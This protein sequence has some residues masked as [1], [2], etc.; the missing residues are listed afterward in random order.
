MKHLR[1]GSIAAADQVV[2]G[3]QAGLGA[4][5]HGDDDLLVGRGRRVAGGEDAGQ[6]GLA[7]RID[8]DLAARRELERALQPVGVGQQADLDEDAFE[9]DM[10]GS[11][12]LMRSW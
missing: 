11:R 2:E 1:S 4:L 3:R 12:R 5:A 10:R 6:R 8:F 9:L 7:A